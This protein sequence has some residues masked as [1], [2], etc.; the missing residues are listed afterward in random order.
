MPNCITAFVVF[1]SLL[2]STEKHLVMY[3]AFF[4]CFAVIFDLTTSV[5]DEAQSLAV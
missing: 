4:L 3:F 1:L 5:T 2:G